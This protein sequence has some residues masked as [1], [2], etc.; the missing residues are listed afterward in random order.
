MCCFCRA[1]RIWEPGE[2]HMTMQTKRDRDSSGLC[3]NYHPLGGVIATGTRDGHVRFWR[4]PR[5]VPSLCH[6]CRAITRYSVST[7]QIEAL[8]LPKRILEY[9]TYRNIP[10]RLKTCCSSDEEDWES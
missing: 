7:Q 3:C 9:L 6:L 5:T 1:L 2:R 10:E 8:P 4:T